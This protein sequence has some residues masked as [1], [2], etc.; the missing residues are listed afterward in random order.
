MYEVTSIAELSEL[1]EEK[2]KNDKTTVVLYRGHGAAS[3]CLRPKVGRHLPPGNS[4]LKKVNE[5]LMLELFR[6]QSV[7][8]LSIA[9]VNDDWELLAIAQHHGL[10]T[11]FLDWTRSPLVALYF[12]VCVECESRR[13]DKGN[14]GL[15]MCEDAEI[16]AWRCNKIDLTNQTKN[17]PKSPLEISK[18]IRY[19]PRFVT[20]RLR[21]QQG[22]FTAHPNPTDEFK[23][24]GDCFRIRISHGKR[25][26]L[27][28]S[29]FRHG[30]HEE[31]LFPD[32]DGLARHIQWCQ[33]K[34][35]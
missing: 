8:R 30:I 31:V 17:L 27:K 10:A 19:V 6:R 3:F 33:T 12:A 14:E 13:K 9:N 23:P 29:L 5:E 20:P 1:V 35:Y 15:P 7:D 34:S 4:N 11:R 32:L 24:D 21:A 16:I 28:N 2:F 25:K 26:H 18:M 22:I